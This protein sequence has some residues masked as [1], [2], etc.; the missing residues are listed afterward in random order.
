[1]IFVLSYT[2][3]DG[4]NYWIDS[5]VFIEDENIENVYI[6][7]T[8]LYKENRLKHDKNIS[9]S[10]IK[11]NIF[12]KFDISLSDINDDMVLETLDSFL[13]KNKRKI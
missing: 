10:D 12:N 13:E 1:M 8:D 4:F 11:I 5:N 2:E 3:T 6:K 9:D 7:L